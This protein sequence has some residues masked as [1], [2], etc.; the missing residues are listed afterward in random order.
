VAGQHRP[1]SVQH[2]PLPVSPRERHAAAAEPARQQRATR[3]QH[4]I[5]DAARTRPATLAKQ[6]ATVW[7]R[8]AQQRFGGA[9]LQPFG[10]LRRVRRF[11]GNRPLNCRMLRVTRQL[12]HAARGAIDSLADAADRFP[13]T[14]RV[15]VG[16]ARQA[17]GNIVVAGQ[18]RH[19]DAGKVARRFHRWRRVAFNQRHVP[20]PGTQ[21]RAGS[22]SRQARTNHDRALFQHGRGRQAR[23]AAAEPCVPGGMR[24]AV[25]HEALCTQ[26]RHL[27]VGE[28]GRLELRAKRRD[29]RQR[30]GEIRALDV[31]QADCIQAGRQLRQRSRQRR[32]YQ[33]K[34][35][36][37]VTLRHAVPSRQQARIQRNHMQLPRTR[38]VTPPLRNQRGAAA[39][40]RVEHGEPGAILPVHRRWQKHAG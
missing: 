14:Q 13:V 29:A 37:G 21:A 3:L 33:V 8:M 28:I 15:Q 10:K 24:A 18:Q 27:F 20:A 26:R 5:A 19:E 23:L 4:R 35:D 39:A 11:A 16:S 12:Q 30:P 22:R 32:R 31:T 25:E 9:L 40:V 7:R 17:G 6:P 1:A 36:P 38:G 2:L 34:R